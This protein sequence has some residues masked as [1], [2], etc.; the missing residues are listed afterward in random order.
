MS[1]R[2]DDTHFLHFQWS[3][4]ALSSHEYFLIIK[5]KKFRHFTMYSSICYQAYD[6][7]TNILTNTHVHEHS[8]FVKLIYFHPYN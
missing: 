3:H 1:I 4:T 8:L 7:H 2:K 5:L 6:K